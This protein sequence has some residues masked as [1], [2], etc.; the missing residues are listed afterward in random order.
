MLLLAAIGQLALRFPSRTLAQR[1]PTFRNTT[2][3]VPK[4]SELLR[5]RV[6]ACETENSVQ[7]LGRRVYPGTSSLKSQQ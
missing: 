2:D 4:G 6:R 5:P 1:I 7:G 3:V